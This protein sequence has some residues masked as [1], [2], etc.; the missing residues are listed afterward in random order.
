MI[1]VTKIVVGEEGTEVLVKPVENTGVVGFCIQM[2]F[3]CERYNV[4]SVIAVNF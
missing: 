4:L 2:L 3:H 1:K